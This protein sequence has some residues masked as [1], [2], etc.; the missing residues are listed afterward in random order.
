[1]GRCGE[2]EILTPLGF[3][4][5]NAHPSLNRLPFYIHPQITFNWNS[6]AAVPFTMPLTRTQSHVD[7]SA[8]VQ[9]TGLVAQTNSATRSSPIPFSVNPSRHKRK[10]PRLQSSAVESCAKT[11][12]PPML[13]NV[14]VCPGTPSTSAV[15]PPLLNKF[16]EL[17]QQIEETY[18][19]DEP[20]PK[21]KNKKVVA[22]DHFVRLALHNAMKQW[23]K[24]R[25]ITRLKSP[26]NV[27]RVAWS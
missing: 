17:I 18:F 23:D 9:P 11:E 4:K 6:I 22:S 21:T 16:E 8:L 7:L 10:I 1:M 20:S 12:P 13:R 25:G 19:S 5:A 2:L 27:A 24:S 14:P 15:A 26:N 3:L